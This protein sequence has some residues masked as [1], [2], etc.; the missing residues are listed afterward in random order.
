MSDIDY[1]LVIKWVFIVIVAGFLG[2]FGKTFATYLIEKARKKK[3]IVTSENLRI[4]VKQPAE[5]SSPI[6]IP[7][8]TETEGKAKK[9]ALKTLVKLRKKEN[10]V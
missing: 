8:T 6:A 2:Q 1:Q 5:S 4:T 7:E 10:N 9:K 3:A